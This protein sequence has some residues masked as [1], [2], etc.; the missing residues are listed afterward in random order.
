MTPNQGAFLELNRLVVFGKGATAYDQPFHKGVNIIRGSNSS[1][2]STIADFIFYVLG[3]DFSKWKPEAEACDSVLADVTINGARVTLKREISRSPRQSM[4]IFWGEY[5]EAQKSSTKGW[6]SFAFQ[7][8]QNKSSFSQVFF[9]ALGLPEVRGDADSNVTMHQLLRLMYVDQLSSVQSLLRDE[10]F[11]APLTRRTIGDLLFGLY[12]DSLYQ[13]EL[14]LR[15]SQRLLENIKGQLSSLYD[16]LNEADMEKDPRSVEKVILENEEQLKRVMNA[17]SSYDSTTSSVKNDIID[18]QI[19]RIRGE[20]LSKQAELNSI[21]VETNQIAIDIADSESFIETLKSRVFALD[22]S[23]TTRQSIGELTLTHCPLCLNA[24][25]GNDDSGTC[26]L[27]KQP[28][29]SEEQT[30]R[31]ARMKQEILFQ[32]KESNSLLITKNDSLSRLE[33][34]IPELEEKV[35]ILKNSLNDEL[36]RV[37]T[38]RNRDLDDLLI[39][40]GQLESDLVSLRRQARALSVLNAL[41]KNQAGHQAKIAS[42]ELSIRSKRGVQSHRLIEAHDTIANIARVLLK[43]DLPRE[44]NFLAPNEISVDFNKNTFAVNGRNEFSASS[45]VYLKNCIHYAIF[46]A[47]LELDYFRYPKFLLC[48]NMED[49]GMEEKRSQSFQELVVKTASEYKGDFQI[50]FT[51]SMISPN[52]EN[53]DFCVGEHYTLQKKALSLPGS[54]PTTK[55]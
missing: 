45:I 47:S 26:P 38:K 31:I 17:L 6:Q 51:T 8:S 24:I 7:R 33:R 9:S 5:E 16:V 36:K 44:E 22:E 55:P 20:Y 1:G 21:R 41:L 49:K 39:K 35:L 52:L 23:L 46:F 13:D 15:D 27:C 3:G 28:I 54:G 40:R 43:S 34:G 50:I 10:M 18:E 2:K 11:D 42:L 30:T 19:Q 53:T 14:S 37:R 48:D 32:I 29:P 12:D 4:S 25:T